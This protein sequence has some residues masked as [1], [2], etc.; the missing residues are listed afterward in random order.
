MCKSVAVQLSWSTSL[1]SGGTK[2]IMK[3][4]LVEFKRASY[5]TYVFEDAEYF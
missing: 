2:K 3:L 4:F 5:E 1:I